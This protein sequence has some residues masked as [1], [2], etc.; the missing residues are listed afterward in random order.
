MRTWLYL[1]CFVLPF[2][3]SARKLRIGVHAAGKPQNIEVRPY[4]GSYTAYSEGQKV[5]NLSEKSLLHLHSEGKFVVVRLGKEVIGKYAKL[6]FLTTSDKASFLIKLPTKNY[7]VYEGNFDVTSQ[8]FVKVVN[9]IDIEEYVKGVIEAESG[10]SD[11]IEF[12]KVQAV[13]SRTYAL[14]HIQ[15]HADEGFDLCDQ[16]H[17]QVFKGRCH[18]NMKIPDAVEAT[19]GLVVAD[20]SMKPIVAAFHSNCGGETS[21]AEDVWSSGLSYLK[22]VRDSFC[23][24]SEHARWSNKISVKQW[25]DYLNKYHPNGVADS[26]T[27]RKD[28][29]YDGTKRES[30]YQWGD[31]KIP[32]KN[33][34]ADW[35]LRSTFFSIRQ[36]EDSLIMSGKGYGHGVG[37]CQEGAMEMAKKGYLFN[38][39]ISF[40][41]NHEVLITNME[42]VDF[43]NN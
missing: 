43:L 41:Y 26:D 40:Y 37:I 11:Q 15:R 3:L 19:R 13:I 34:R 29:T 33:I 36:E 35:K 42:T 28:F 12:L 38:D 14:S 22:T 31:V 32:F 16:V 2:T 9:Q 18:F 4:S 20:R 10:S 27:V 23:C 1:F 6:K 5:F 24:N 25:T 30:F 39:I 17:C 21:N 7:E 8:N